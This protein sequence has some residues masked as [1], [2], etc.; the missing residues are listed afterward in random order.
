M[1]KRKLGKETTYTTILE[2]GDKRHR[3]GDLAELQ[4]PEAGVLSI[5]ATRSYGVLVGASGRTY[6]W[7]EGLCAERVEPC[8]DEVGDA[9]SSSPF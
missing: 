1:P 4:V 2:L 8:D 7:G 9:F 6:E 3:S 5:A